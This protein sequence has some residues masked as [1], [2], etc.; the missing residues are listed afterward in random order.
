MKNT[1]A[2]MLMAG[3]TRFN[4]E[5]VAAHIGTDEVLFEELITIMVTTKTPLPERAAWVMSTVTDSYPWMIFP[6]FNRIIDHMFHCSNSSLNR[7]ILRLLTNIEIPEEKTGEIFEFCYK[8]LNDQKQPPAVRVH[9]M[10][11][12]FNISEKEPD[13]KPELKL[14][15]ENQLENA[16]TG[17]AN[18]AEKLI[19]KL[20]GFNK[21][22]R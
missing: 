8:S 12:L 4:T 5:L 13:L 17:F 14:L 19:K 3:N 15:I 1:L 10:Q 22:N 6:H 20:S 11:I 16:S 9:A 18:R 7:N 21:I 2:D